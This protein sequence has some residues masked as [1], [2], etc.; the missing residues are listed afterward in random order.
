MRYLST[1]AALL[2]GSPA[3]A[4]DVLY[5]SVAGEKRIAIYHVDSAEGRL[6]RVGDASTTGEPAGNFKIAL[7]MRRSLAHPSTMGAS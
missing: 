1:L 4:A 3:F 6:T 2:L 7:A 5:V